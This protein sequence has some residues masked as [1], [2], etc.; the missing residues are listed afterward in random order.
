MRKHLNK[1]ITF[2]TVILS[3][4]MCSLVYADPTPTP[5]QGNSYTGTLSQAAEI[6]FTNTRQV[7]VPTNASYPIYV[8]IG[9]AALSAAFLIFTIMQRRASH[10]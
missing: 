3:M 1:V 6:T 7:S 4:L 8:F 10:D 9:L 2:M 5:I